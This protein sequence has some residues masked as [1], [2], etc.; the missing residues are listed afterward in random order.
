[1]PPPIKVELV[2]HSPH[3]ATS[4]AE[5]AARLRTALGDLLVA[6]HH[7]GSTSV[8]GLC[9]KPILDLLPVVRSV[10]ILDERR[11]ALERLGFRSWG[12]YGIAGRRYFTLDDAAG[13]RRVQLHCFEPNSDE[14]ERHIAFRDYLRADPRAAREYEAEKLR[15][16]D[17]HPDDSHAYSDAK[18]PWIERTLPAAL[19]FAGRRP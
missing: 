13:T 10:E 18:S 14:I 19:E 3:W 2:A 5:E 8:P 1:M 12:E 16:R 15:C 9:A 11:D 17:L 7:V 4:A 6:V